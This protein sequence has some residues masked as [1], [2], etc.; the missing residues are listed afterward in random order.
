MKTCKNC[1]IIKCIDKDS[2]SKACSKWEGRAGCDI[3]IYNLG[4]ACQA[5]L[6]G[7]K[8]IGCASLDVVSF[9][10]ELCIHKKECKN[11]CEE[12]GIEHI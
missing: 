1:T 4:P 2:D 11:Q 8:L 12:L 3:C 9:R 7:S 6:E 10:C 5:S